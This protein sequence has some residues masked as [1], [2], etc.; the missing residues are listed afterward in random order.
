MQQPRCPGATGPSEAPL[1]RKVSVRLWRPRTLPGGLSAAASPRL[2]L[3]TTMLDGSDPAPE[4]GRSAHFG[5]MG[6]EVG[7]RVLLRPAVEGPGE[8]DSLPAS[9][10][11]VLLQDKH[12]RYVTLG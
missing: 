11:K 6:T 4:A 3:I 1:A 8:C 7:D 12:E 10:R 2:V 9:R 5:P